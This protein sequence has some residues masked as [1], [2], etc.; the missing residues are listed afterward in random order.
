MALVGQS[1]DLCHGVGGIAILEQY[2]GTTIHNSHRDSLWLLDAALWV[3]SFWQVSFTMVGIVGSN[4]NP[5]HV[6][7]DGMHA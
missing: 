4:R 7:H 2:P 6:S 1:G 3:D 5:L